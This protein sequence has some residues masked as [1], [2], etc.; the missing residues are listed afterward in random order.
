MISGIDN[1]ESEQPQIGFIMQHE[2]IIQT[3][4]SKLKASN[5]LM[6]SEQG[7][8]KLLGLSSYEEYVKSK[9]ISADE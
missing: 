9:S 2:D 8:L 3:S 5:S 4:L 7:H 6:I 1:S